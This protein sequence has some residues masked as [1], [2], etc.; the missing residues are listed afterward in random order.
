MPMMPHSRAERNYGYSFRNDLRGGIWTD[1]HFE[2][3]EEMINSLKEDIAPTSVFGQLL[4]IIEQPDGR[5]MQ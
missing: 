2:T 4:R 5:Q 3:K 1:R